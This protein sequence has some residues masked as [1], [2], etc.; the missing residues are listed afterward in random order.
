MSETH[1][2][3]EATPTENSESLWILVLAPLI[4]AVHFLACYLT[5]AIW[6]EKF[7]LSEE[8]LAPVRWAYLIFTMGAI[9]GI[10]LVGWNGYRR[11][12]EAPMAH[13]YDADHPDDR[14]RF[15]GFATVLLAGLSLVA[16]LF[17]AAVALFLETCH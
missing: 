16:T 1:D 8:N 15:L 12:R 9:A 3:S 14:H 17:V 10:V 11:I 5:I 2:R 13:P 7:A 6:C 4:W